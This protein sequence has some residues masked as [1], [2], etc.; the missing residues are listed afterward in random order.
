MEILNTKL[1]LSDAAEILVMLGFFPVI[2]IGVILFLNYLYE[3][4]AKGMIIGIAV[5]IAGFLM[6]AYGNSM[7][8]ITTYDVILTDKSYYELIEEYEI[9]NTE[10]KI[11]TITEKGE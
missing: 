10:G 9:L 4:K 7:P 1:I 2:T 6:M 8:K 3:E 11:I 5:I